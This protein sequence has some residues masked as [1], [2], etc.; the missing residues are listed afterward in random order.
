MDNADAGKDIEEQETLTLDTQPLW[1]PI[2]VNPDEQLQPRIDLNGRLV[3]HPTR[4]EI[5]L[6]DNGYRRHIPNPWTFTNLFR[7]NVG[8]ME[9]DKIDRIPTGASLPDGA[10]LLKPHNSDMIYLIDLNCKRHVTSPETMEKYGLAW[11]QVLCHTREHLR[12]CFLEAEY[13]MRE[14]DGALA[15]I[16]YQCSRSARMMNE[17][18]VSVSPR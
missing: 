11:H 16:C 14:S 9:L 17:S 15:F 1:P 6:I 7:R 12:F 13:R 3:R 8:I 2:G 18:V 5:Y 10:V 4:P